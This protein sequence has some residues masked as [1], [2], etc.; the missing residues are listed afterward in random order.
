MAVRMSVSGRIDLPDPTVVIPWTQVLLDSH[1]RLMGRELIA[2][3]GDPLEEAV[4]LFVAPF[5]VASHDTAAEPL[6]NYGNRAALS[7]WE[8]PWERFVRTPSRDT[9]EAVG[10]RERER[11]LEEVGRQGYVTGY[12]G[13]RISATGRRFRIHDVTIW[14]L[15]D[16][17]GRRVGQ[18]ATF[19]HWTDE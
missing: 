18:A 8:L 17:D 10:R 16:R 9:A 4:R 12:S 7:L 5:V 14:D 13:V 6:L 19:R 15:S 2:R 3:C 11:V 1:A